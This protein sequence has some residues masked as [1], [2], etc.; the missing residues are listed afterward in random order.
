MESKWLPKCLLHLNEPYLSEVDEMVIIGQLSDAP[1]GGYNGLREIYT[2]LVPASRLEE[3]LSNPGGIGSRV[4]SWGPRPIVDEGKSYNTG[5]WVEGPG[6]SDDRLEPIVVGWEY[7][8]NTVMIPDNGL[9]MC[10]GLSPRILK[11]ADRIIWDD[12]S[13]PEYGIITVKPLSHYDM[14]SNTGA[15]VRINRKYLEDFASLKNCSVVAVYYEER[16]CKLDEEIEDILADKEGISLKQPG[17]RIDIVRDTYH[18]D[19]AIL[20]R[21]W[22]CRLVMQPKHRPITEEQDPELE[23]TDYPGIMTHDRAMKSGLLN[24]VYVSDQVLE[25]FEGKPEFEIHPTLGAVSYDGWWSLGYSHRIGR[26]YIAYELK[27]LYEGCPPSI[28]AHTHVFSVSKATAE[29]Q[30]RLLGNKNIGTRTES[31]IK[32]YLDFGDALMSLSERYSLPFEA[33]D[34]IGLQRQEV[35]YQGWYRVNSLKPLAYHA[36]LTMTRE[37]FLDRCKDVWTLFEGLKEKTL[38]RLMNSIG[39]SDEETKDMKSLKLM[40]TVLQLCSIANET[41][42]DITKQKDEVCKRWNKDIRL[43][44]LT[45]LF[46]LF[47][48]RT[49]AS[50]ELG[51]DEARKVRSAIECFDLHED[52][53]KEGWGNALDKIYDSIATNITNLSRLLHSV[54]KS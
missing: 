23:W 44:E 49:A 32:A 27:K 20:C 43:N 29:T 4:K 45:P 37:R 3:V 40:S 1:C 21:I 52:D 19:D 46:A 15:D 53:M 16:R 41:G 31:L 24:Y 33:E 36:P 54:A 25:A 17:R 39:I 48:L 26:D 2:V 38:R 50:H 18:G 42:L 7:H 8:N 13:H 35:E 10:Y 34:I 22:G 30:A 51:S 14:H 9:L 28:I 11:E 6:G 47:D 5:F 12:L